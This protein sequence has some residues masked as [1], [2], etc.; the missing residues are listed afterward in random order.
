MPLY[1]Y[2][3]QHCGKTVDAFRKIDERND[4][5]FCCQDAMQRVIGQHNVHTFKPYWD[6]NMTTQPVY[7]ESAKQRKALLKKHNLTELY[8]KKWM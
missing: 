5:I 4:P 8:G 2:I 3:C 7:V 6:P 1:S